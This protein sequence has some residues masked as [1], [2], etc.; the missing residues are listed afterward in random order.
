LCDGLL[1]YTSCGNVCD[2]IGVLYVGLLG[3]LG[4]N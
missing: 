3:G 4:I 2:H 1:S